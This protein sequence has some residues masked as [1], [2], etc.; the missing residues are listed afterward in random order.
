V[1]SHNILNCL[2]VNKAESILLTFWLSL[3]KEYGEKFRL[4]LIMKNIVH[5]A[6][7]L[8]NIDSNK[9]LIQEEA[10]NLLSILNN[11][12]KVNLTVPLNTSLI[13]KEKS[14][15]KDIELRYKA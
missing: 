7:D 8:S 10:S 12:R 5:I 11:I 4:L 2:R 9:V 1:T 15:I 13:F 6:D 3:I 14:G